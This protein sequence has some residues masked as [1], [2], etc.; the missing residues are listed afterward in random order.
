MHLIQKKL[1]GQDV[2]YTLPPSLI[3]P[4]LRASLLGPSPFSP[5]TVPPHPEPVVDLVSFDDTP[6]P[7]AVQMQPIPLAGT[8]K[9]QAPGAIANTVPKGPAHLPWDNDPFSVPSQTC[10]S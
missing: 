3:P 8:V 5:A 6:P 7:T 2:P 4:G 1:T 10:G 9:L